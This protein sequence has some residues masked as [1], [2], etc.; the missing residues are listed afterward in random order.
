MKDLT[1]NEYIIGNI[2]CVIKSF[3]PEG[4]YDNTHKGRHSECLVMVISGEAEYSFGESVFRVQKDDVIFLPKNSRYKISVFPDYKFIYVDFEICSEDSGKLSCMVYNPEPRKIQEGFRSL[5][6]YWTKGE[7]KRLTKAR[8]LLY[9]IYKLLLDSITK[10]KNRH[11]SVIEPAIRMIAEQSEKSCLS[12][13]SLADICGISSV[14]LRRL[15]VKQF[16][17]SPIKYISHQK[18]ERAKELLKYDLL[19]ITDISEM[20]GFSGIDYFCRTF[21]KETGFTPGEYRK[22][23]SR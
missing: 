19:S 11:L 23:Y 3:M 12:V 9:S 5:L 2:H 10:E 16:G 4:F 14:H 6:F 15:F 7:R 21:K 18:T 1:A 17:I 22:L 13:E 20:L 8:E